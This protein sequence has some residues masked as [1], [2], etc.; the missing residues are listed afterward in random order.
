MESHAA[1]ASSNRDHVGRGVVAGTSVQSKVADSLRGHAEGLLGHRGSNPAEAKRFARY[2]FAGGCATA[3]HYLVLACG[4]ELAA[5]P[6]AP[7]A[8]IGALAGAMVSFAMNRL[9]TFP[10]GDARLSLGRFSVVA[11]AGMAISAG[12]V[13]F[14]VARLN[15]GWLASQAVATALVL[16]AGFAANLRW[17]YR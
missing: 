14:G 13:H 1:E 2:V 16:V 9:F 10:D 15:A 5:V 17:S 12:V 11:A 6:P 3:V 8:G 4:V 7:A